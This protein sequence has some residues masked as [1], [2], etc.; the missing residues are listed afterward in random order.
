MLPGFYLYNPSSASFLG[1][2]C[3]TF[4][5][6][7]VKIFKRKERKERRAKDAKIKGVRHD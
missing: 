2:L 3:D 1:D 6:F 4:A 5:S 7:A